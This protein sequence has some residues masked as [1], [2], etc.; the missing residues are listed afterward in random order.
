MI[1]KVSVPR[2]HWQELDQL[3]LDDHVDNP[4]RFAGGG[5]N[6]RGLIG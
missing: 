6:G 3:K 1:I 5:D 2:T 4:Q